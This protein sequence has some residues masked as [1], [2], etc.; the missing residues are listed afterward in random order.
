[1]KILKKMSD[2][3]AITLLGSVIVGLILGL[4]LGDSAS[5]LAPFGTIFTRLLKMMV[6]VLVLF[7][8]ASAFAN[9]GDARKMSKWGG[10]VIGYFLLT[11]TIASVIGII[12]GLV[13]KP[14]AGLDIS[15]A[16][17]E[18]A[19]VSIDDFI[20]WLP[21]NF[22]GCIAEGNTIQ[23]V[24]LAIFVGIA[25]VL[26]KEKKYQESIT[27]FLN[28]GQELILTIIKGIMLYAPI[29]IAALTATSISDMKGSLMSEMTS[30]LLAYS[31]AFVLQVVIC[32]FGLLRIIG[33]VN[34]FKFTKKLFPALITA[35]TT[36]S[37]AATLPVTLQCT[38]D[39]GVDE[40]IA[41]FAIPLGVTFNMDSM[42]L[43]IPLYIMLG[44]YAIGQN[45]TFSNLLLFVIMGIAFSVGCAGVP[46][47]GLAIAVILVAA[48]GL[49]TQVV[50]WISAVFFFLDTTGT[51][52][53]I[54]GDAVCSVIVARGEG[55]LDDAKFNA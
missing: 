26:M 12:C 13:F 32:Y 34:P 2:N 55:L 1:M 47:G 10:K 19:K 30:F 42:G 5:V 43:E 50:A 35:F 20:A 45:P 44:M 48:F 29:G 51:A 33:K 39:I 52:M 38:K 46:G 3:F 18:V 37:S 40:G 28:A 31:V 41:D 25:V 15:G 22:L 11:T 23:I 16:A 14:G 7:S 54:W 53:N 21:G 6:P 49:P 17:Q 4:L 27:H 9:I 8:I 36:T 24:F